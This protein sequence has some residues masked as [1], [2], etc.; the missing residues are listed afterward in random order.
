MLK[1]VLPMCPNC[2]RRPFAISC[3][4]QLARLLTDDDDILSTRQH[5]LTVTD[6]LFG[7]V[8]QSWFSHV[9]LIASHFGILVGIEISIRESNI[10]MST[11]LFEKRQK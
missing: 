8:R 11:L 1:Q 5:V 7:Q 2:A 6:N 10:L 4:A 9:F 3:L